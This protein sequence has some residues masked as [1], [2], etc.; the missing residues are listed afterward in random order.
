METKIQAIKLYEDIKSQEQ[1]EN[2]K[3]PAIS[4]NSME[5]HNLNDRE[6]KI[7]IIKKIL[8]E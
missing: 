3:Y 4:P 8:N 6:F 1:K 2:D 7:T 5:I